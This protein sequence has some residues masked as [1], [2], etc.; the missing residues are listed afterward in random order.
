MRP[1]STS[2][3]LPNSVA[4]LSAR[5]GR[6]HQL[7]GIG[8]VL[9]SLA[10]FAVLDTSIQYV[11]AS[12][13]LLMAIWVRYAFQAVSATALAWP[14]RGRAS[15]HT[16][17]LN[18]QVL[19]GLLLVASSSLAFL[20]L[21]FMPVSEY[22]AVVMITPIVITLMAAHTLKERV[23]GLRWALVCGGFLGVLIIVRPSRADFSWALLLPLMLVATNSAFQ[24][25]TSKL[26]RSENP[27]TMQ[28]YTGWVGFAVSSIAV[29]FVWASLPAGMWWA[30]LAVGLMGSAGHLLFI[31]AYAHAPAATLTPYL[32]A[33]IG[34]AMLF[35]WVAFA[36]VPDTASLMGMGLIAACGALSAWLT[37]RESR[38]AAQP[39]PEPVES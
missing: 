16:E 34:F 32:Y 24:L 22:T 19:R 38:A 17:H 12:V 9:A 26:A 15:F 20:S 8:L 4:A 27:L 14:R 33:Q 5:R 37:M 6:N 28:L 10:C 35:G 2:T 7:L 1:E 11:S 13:P 31:F 36:Y 18:Y 25:L 3:H 29:P 23:S 30:L 39:A 21:R